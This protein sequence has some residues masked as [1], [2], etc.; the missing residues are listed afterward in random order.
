MPNG[1]DREAIVII[2]TTK[3][4]KCGNWCADQGLDESFDRSFTKTAA[5]K[6]SAMLIGAGIGSIVPGIGT[7]IGAGVGYLVS[8]TTDKMIYGDE[9]Y[10]FICSQCGNKFTESK[11][12]MIT[13]LFIK[14]NSSEIGR[15]VTE[16]VIDQAHKKDIRPHFSLEKVQIEHTTLINKLNNEFD[17]KIDSQYWLAINSSKNMAEF[18]NQIVGLVE[19]CAK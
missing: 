2:M 19:Q 17:I 14:E 12:S 9:Q 18:I 5:K 6:G 7:L 3:C 15:R 4:P 1:G 11:K 16:I 10:L 13:K 8:K